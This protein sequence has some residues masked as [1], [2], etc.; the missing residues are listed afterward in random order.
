M[1]ISK[2]ILPVLTAATLG[3]A[4]WACDGGTGP[5]GLDDFDAPDGTASRAGTVESASLSPGDPSEG[6]I[7]LEGDI[8]VRITG[9]TDIDEGGDFVNLTDVLNALEDGTRIRIEFEGEVE[10]GVI[11]AIEIRFESDDDDDG[12]NDD[13]EDDDDEGDDDED[14]DDE[15]DLDEVHGFVAA[16]DL[17][18]RTITLT[19]GR[20]LHISG[21][22]LIEGDGDFL[23]LADVSSA[24][25]AGLEVRLEAD[26][27]FGAG[28]LEVTSV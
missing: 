28:G 3:L 5:A 25:A 10:D 2:L 15:E 16:V 23:T 7:V 21:D 13:D 27:E 1:Q 11:T 19:D 17:A 6:L 26:L 18:A 12:E 14:D 8:L 9:E 22:D 4:G 24:V 20:L